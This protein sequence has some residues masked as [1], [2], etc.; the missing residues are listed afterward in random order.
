MTETAMDKSRLAAFVDGELSPEDAADV[1]MHL[2]DHPA[3][4]AYVDELMALNVMIADAYDAPL[5]EPAP[6]AILAT[7]AANGEPSSQPSNVTPFPMARLVRKPATW[8]LGGVLAAGLATFM[9]TNVPG[10]GDPGRVALGPLPTDHA[11]TYALN[12]LGAGQTRRF[13]DE[14]EFSVTASFQTEAKGVCREF[15]I[16]QDASG[17]F[18]VGVACPAE[19]ESGGWVIEVVD[20]L[21]SDDT[22]ASFTPASGA[23][24]DPIGDFLDNVGAG[25]MLTPEEEEAARAA[26]WKRAE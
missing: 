10:T 25:R 16:T 20:T 15:R 22:A 3:D 14:T 19:G 7:I 11:Q 21:G 5:H 12:E 18:D 1:V 23:Q 4:Q 9:I 2:A 26:G 13:G 24:A 6:D 17:R 8:G